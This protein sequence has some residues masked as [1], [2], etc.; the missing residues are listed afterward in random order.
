MQQSAVPFP[1][2][3]GRRVHITRTP[4]RARRRTAVHLLTARRPGNR[5]AEAR[6][7]SDENSTTRGNRVMA[8]CLAHGT[9]FWGPPR[10]LSRRRTKGGLPISRQSDLGSFWEPQRQHVMPL[11]GRAWKSNRTRQGDGSLLA[12]NTWTGCCPARAATTA[13]CRSR[14][15]YGCGDEEPLQSSCAWRD[16]AA[17]HGSTGSGRVP[18]SDQCATRLRCFNHAIPVDL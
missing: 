10:S 5:A 2:S 9:V 8:W 16:M 7:Y 3:A 11:P 14:G 4:V 12:G 13:S 17:L 15:R 1:L 6:D 18:P